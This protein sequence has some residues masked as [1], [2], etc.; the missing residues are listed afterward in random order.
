MRVSHS[1]GYLTYCNLCM[2][3]S[4][5]LIYGLSKNAS[6][7]TTQVLESCTDIRLQWLCPNADKCSTRWQLLRQAFP[8]ETIVEY[9]FRVSYSNDPHHC[10]ADTATCMLKHNTLSSYIVGQCCPSVL[11]DMIMIMIMI[12]VRFRK[13]LIMQGLLHACNC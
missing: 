10:S 4:L 11:R 8:T 7:L 9:L 1:Q 13:T 6:L 12:I 2:L 5:Y 3:Q